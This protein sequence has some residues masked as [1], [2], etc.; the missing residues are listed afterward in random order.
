MV[1]NKN[2]T[3]LAIAMILE[4]LFVV[5]L[6]ATLILASMTYRESKIKI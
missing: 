5:V 2:A 1:L 3:I 4:Y 6:V